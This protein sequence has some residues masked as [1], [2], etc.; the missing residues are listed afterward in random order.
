MRTAWLLLGVAACDTGERDVAPR[1][2]R[3]S[4]GVRIVENR[5]PELGERAWRLVEPPVLDIGLA[6]GPA[7]Q[8]LFR[9]V[10]SARLDDG[11]VV[12]ANAGT[13]ELRLFDRAG[14]FVRSI[15]R[16]GGG[17]GEFEDLQW[18]WVLNGD[19]LLAY[20]FWPGRLSVFDTTGTYVRS[21][22]LRIPDGRQSLVAG[23]FGDGSLA[24]MGAPRFAGPG[25]Q[26]GAFR[27]SISVYHVAADGSVLGALGRF[28]WAETWRA[29]F[30][31]GMRAISIPFA[32]LPAWT[33]ADDAFV[34]AAGAAH[35]VHFVAP[36]GRLARVVRIA[37]S[38][39]AVRPADLARYRE[40]ILERAA[41]EGIRPAMERALAAVPVPETM[42]A[43]SG[44]RVDRAGNLWIET[45]EPEPALPRRWLIVDPQGLWL[46][47]LE[48]PAGFELHA[49]APDWVLGRHTD[50]LGVERIRLYRI[51]SRTGNTQD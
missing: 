47:T 31:D 50:D 42:P 6:D 41:R 22:S 15:G 40:E 5:A 18:V 29:E 2:E 30:D 8:Q 21:T 16:R 19:T 37:Q 35:D 24:V 46:T 10:R 26:A 12:I 17:P 38:P 13:S 7:S 51:E 39:R 44:L 9:A 49:A 1:V 25:S 4:A 11:R 3:D 27:D 48:L 43:L 36:G 45:Y 33:V 20:D 14:R 28:P 32:P 23:L 34:Y